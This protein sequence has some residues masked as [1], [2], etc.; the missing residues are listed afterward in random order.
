V[1]AK[2]KTV[3]D[4]QLHSMQL[5]DKETVELRV[6]SSLVML[7]INLRFSIAIVTSALAR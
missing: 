4:Y 7:A 1:A 3:Y 6:F 5:S 2:E